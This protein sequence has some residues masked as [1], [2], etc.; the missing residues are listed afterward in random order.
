M[1]EYDFESRYYYDTG[2]YQVWFNTDLTEKSDKFRDPPR[3][4]PEPLAWLAAHPDVEW[5][6]EC[7]M[8]IFP[9]PELREEF[10]SLFIREENCHYRD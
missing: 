4:K 5:N 7:I 1:S 3:L 9:S 8:W 2:L 6:A 10:K